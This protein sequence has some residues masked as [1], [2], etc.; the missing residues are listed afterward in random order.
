V[1]RV[2]VTGAGAA[3]LA[4]RRVRADTDL[5]GRL[6]ALSADDLAALARAVDVLEHMLEAEQ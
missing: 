1:V 5:A 6:Q 2:A 3:L 4:E